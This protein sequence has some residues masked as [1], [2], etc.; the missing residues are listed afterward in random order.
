[1]TRH[2]GIVP[3]RDRMKV[4][5]KI[6]WLVGIGDFVLLLVFAYGGEVTH[7]LAFPD[8]LILSILQAAL[9]FALVWFPTVFAI[10]ALTDPRA[11]RRSVVVVRT[12]G[13]W[14]IAAPLGIVFRALI[15]NRSVIPLAFLLV[16]Y[17]LGIAFF[18]GW[19]VLILLFFYLVRSVRGELR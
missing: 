12:V 10:G 6:S 18:L 2:P 4:S 14:L 9:P 5:R 17:A 13:A 19:R 7:D 8:S 15:I 11:L 16:T 1:M 3:G